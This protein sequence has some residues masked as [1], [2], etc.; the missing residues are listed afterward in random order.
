MMRR[1]GGAAALLSAALLL[2]AAPARAASGPHISVLGETLSGNLASFVVEATG[3][4]PGQS[5]AVT[6][7]SATVDGRPALATVT[8][9]VTAEL[10]R[11]V[12]VVVDT[13]GSMA[14]APIA[15]A[16]RAAIGFLTALPSDVK[17]GLI[18]FSDQV[19]V[20]SRPTTDHVAVA[21]AV[22]GLRA[23]GETR[24]YDA[25]LTAAAS[26][27]T[28]GERELLLLSDGGDTRSSAHL[29]QVT[30]TL[31]RDGDRLNAIP[32][33]TS[34]S[35]A[36]ALTALARASGGQALPATDS[37]GLVRAFNQAART[38]VPRL[39]I[40]VDLT[41]ATAG[42]RLPVVL[43]VPSA[44]GI[45]TAVAQVDTPV[46]GPPSKGASP[47][48]LTG[49]GLSLAVEVAAVVLALGLLG[50]LVLGL[51]LAGETVL[52]RRR[53][54]GIRAYETAVAPTA[55]EPVAGG[56]RESA[57]GKGAL[58][59]ASRLVDA[60]GLE[61]KIRPLLDAAG[62][63]L[64]SEEF[65]LLCGGTGIAMLVLLTLLTHLLLLGVLVGLPLGVVAVV[66]LARLK[67]ERRR[68][69]FVMALPDSLQLV[70]SALSAGFSFVQALDNLVRQGSGPLVDELSR[71]LA[72]ARLGVPIEDCLDQIA[73]RMGSEDFSWAV[74]AVRVQR[75][76]GGNLAE[77]LTTVTETLRERERLR[78][79]VRALSAEGR[80]SAYILIALPIG[81]SLYMFS[82]RRSYIRPLY[83]EG[84]GIVMLAGAVLLLIVGWFV[85]R[86][87]VKVEL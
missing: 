48:L 77:I 7:I 13:S 20:L 21:S 50:L 66:E 5:L 42:S 33:R 55:E 31:Q 51:D 12:V 14:G 75:E 22:A 84:A 82:V 70:A 58:S 29:A 15:E 60:R 78:R 17:A 18:A 36:Q 57:V 10:S 46:A 3:L 56:L 49:H 45:L 80:L 6:G 16:K 40:Q 4:A 34:E 72:Q 32:F 52:R 39:T 11:T 87:T 64:R 68:R 61:A 62:W 41:G 74:M 44:A 69:A 71:A 73:D 43:H 35:F 27:G 79:Q 67:A 86:K 23:G 53:L 65:V 28:V 1:T 81:M 2:A 59:A 37:A 19:Q 26:A 30:A 54:D 9:T 63:T 47:G 24:L 8:D 25:L 76:V 85:M 83:T 38:Y